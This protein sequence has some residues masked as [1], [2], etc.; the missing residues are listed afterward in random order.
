MDL[1]DLGGVPEKQFRCCSLA[2]V[3]QHML[4]FFP[5]SGPPDKSC[6]DVESDEVSLPSTTCCQFW[7]AKF[8]HVGRRNEVI[9]ECVSSNVVSTVG[10][11]LECP[12]PPTKVGKVL[13]AAGCER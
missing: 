3:A 4:D 6:T 8:G 13:E 10:K 2:P 1:L 9:L 12:L 5:L 11:D 7:E